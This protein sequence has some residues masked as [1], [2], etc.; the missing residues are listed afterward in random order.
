LPRDILLQVKQEN[1]RRETG[2]KKPDPTPTF[3]KRLPISKAVFS[4]KSRKH[5]IIWAVPIG[6]MYVIYIYPHLA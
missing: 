3:F 4:T 5:I 2:G 6:S 1:A